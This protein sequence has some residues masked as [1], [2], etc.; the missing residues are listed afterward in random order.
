MEFIP[1]Y[2][3]RKIGKEEIEYMYPDLKA[4]LIRKY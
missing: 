1:S 3:A 2:I 4:E